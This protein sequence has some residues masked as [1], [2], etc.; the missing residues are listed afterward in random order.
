MKPSNVLLDEDM[1][2]HV[3]DFGLA[4][5]LASL[6]DSSQKQ[7]STSSRIK[8]TIGYTPPGTIFIFDWAKVQK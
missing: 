7:A 5:V 8:G 4:R 2:A 6:I 3:S 1:V